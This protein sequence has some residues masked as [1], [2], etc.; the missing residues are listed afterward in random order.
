[1]PGRPLPHPFASPHRD[2]AQ[3]DAILL[4]IDTDFYR[5]A[6]HFPLGGSRGHSQTPLSSKGAKARVASTGRWRAPLVRAMKS[7]FRFAFDRSVR[8]IDHDSHLHVSSSFMLLRD[9]DELARAAPPPSSPER[10]EP[11]EAI[12]VAAERQSLID[13]TEAA[14][15][16]AQTAAYEARQRHGATEAAIETAKTAATAH[17]VAVAAGKAGPPPQTIREVRNNL[18]D[19]VDDLTAAEGALSELRSEWTRLQAAWKVGA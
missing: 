10:A 5:I 2:A 14:V 6:A 13:A 1:M 7:T 8:T 11:P 17:P 9:P 18:A 19:A 16:L 15:G 12:R 4:G 3:E